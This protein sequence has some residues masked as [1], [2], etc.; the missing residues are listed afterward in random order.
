MDFRLSEEQQQL[1]MTVRA[2]L[3]AT[4]PESQVRRLMATQSGYD[5]LVWR[6]LAEQL[7]LHSIAIPSEYGGSGFGYVELGVVFEEFGRSLLCA[8]FFATVAL[9]A[10][11]LLRCGDS[12]A[13]REFLPA[14][15]SGATIATFAL[16]EGGQWRQEAVSLPARRDG[17]SWLITG[18][19]THVLD[20]ATADLILV[21]ARTAN[22][23]GVFAVPSDAPGLVRTPVE[24]LDL[25]RKQAHLSFTDTPVRLIG[26]P[27]RAWAGIA[28]ALDSAAILLAAE[29]VGGSQR[30]M[31]MAVKYAGIREQFGRPIG[32]FQAVKHIC[33]DMLVHTESARSAA[34]HGMWALDAGQNVPVSASIAKSFC[35]TAYAQ[36]AA[37]NIQ[38]HGGIGFTW[39]HSAHLYFKRATSS[40]LLLGSPS[41]HREALAQRLGL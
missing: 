22:G 23:V 5:S 24:T 20:G 3:A 38:I 33:A 8:P 7:G 13:K 6:Q 36:V 2:F 12:A 11:V 27:A 10:E 41:H 26:D 29:Q 28:A 21:A 32:S 35:S 14:I 9:A 18:E 16:S 34:Y 25:T 15:S 19:M 40:A 39:E 37:D 4:S 31:E 17:T 1:Q 30:A